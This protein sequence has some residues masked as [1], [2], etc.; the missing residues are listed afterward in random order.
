M[1]GFDNTVCTSGYRIDGAVTP[2]A[3][4]TFQSW[5]P[6]NASAYWGCAPDAASSVFVERGQ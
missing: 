2:T 1:I 5:Y 6:A 4:A 3:Q